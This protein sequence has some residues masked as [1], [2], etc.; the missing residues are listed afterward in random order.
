MRKGIQL[1][2]LSPEKRHSQTFLDDLLTMYREAK[3]AQQDGRLSAAGRER[4]VARLETRIWDVAALH[5]KIW[6]SPSTPDERDF[7]NLVQELFRL[8][9]TNELFRFVRHPE[10]EPTN[11][12]SERELRGPARCRKTGRTNKTP[13]G[14]QRQSVIT[15]VLRS[16]QKHLPVFTLSQVV[17]EVLSWPERGLSLFRQQLAQTKTL[18]AQPPPT[19]ARRG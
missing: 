7:A 6:E 14:A 10:V 4:Q 9:A 12:V 2:L 8:V 5:Q 17:T 11:N 15:S 18:L 13:Q 1:A 3:S 16:L 19:L